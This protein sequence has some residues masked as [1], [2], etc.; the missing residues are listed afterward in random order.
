AHMMIVPTNLTGKTFS[1]SVECADGSTYR[2]TTPQIGKAY[3]Q[4]MRYTATIA[5]SGWTKADESTAEV[6]DNNTTTA[7]GFAFGD[8]SEEDPYVIATPGQLKYL[9][10]QV[11]TNSNYENKHIRL[12]TDIKVAE[13][14]QWQPIGMISS[15]PFKG[16]FDG[17]GHTIYGKLANSGYNYFGFFGYINSG[18]VKNLHVKADIDGGANGTGMVYVGGI[19]GYATSATISDCSY[20]GTVTG[21]VGTQASN[22]GGVIGYAISTNISNCTVQGEVSGSTL[23]VDKG[24]DNNTGGITGSIGNSTQ[25]QSCTNKANVK[26]SSGGLTAGTSRTG[27]IIGYCSGSGAINNCNNEGEITVQYTNSGYHCFVGGLA[28]TTAT[29]TFTGCTNT[30]KVTGGQ[31]AEGNISYCGGLVGNI[32]TLHL[33]LNAASATV[34]GGSGG[35]TYTGG[36]AGNASILGAIYNCCTNLATVDGAAASDANRLGGGV[37]TECNEGHQPRTDE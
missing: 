15:S 37:V 33:C 4:G 29:F 1:V 6:F 22:T 20:N 21:R 32:G 17:S 7:T 34:T 35:T 31:V 2:F 13:D 18:S 26:G 24:G 12:A 3:K 36:L 16:H 9:V 10:N 19:T 23:S 30:G 8:G 27:G 5:G 11:S 14:V 28:G 25:I